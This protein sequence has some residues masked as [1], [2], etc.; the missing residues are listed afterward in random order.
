MTHL[1]THLATPKILKPEQVAA[2]NRLR[3]YATSDPCANPPQGH[4]VALWRR[5][6]GC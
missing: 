3:G 6:N 1:E 2:Y 4:D 5:H